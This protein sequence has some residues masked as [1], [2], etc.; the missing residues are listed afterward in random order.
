MSQ[1]ET[2][3]CGIPRFATQQGRI[4]WQE[5]GHFVMALCKN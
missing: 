4:E 3:I 1:A 5:T 2:K